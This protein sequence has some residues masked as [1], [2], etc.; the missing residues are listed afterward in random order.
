MTKERPGKPGRIVSNRS[1]L[2][3]AILLAQ[4][5]LEVDF[6]FEE[7]FELEAVEEVVTVLVKGALRVLQHTDSHLLAQQHGLATVGTPMY[8]GNIATVGN[9]NTNLVQLAFYGERAASVGHQRP[10]RFRTCAEG[11]Y[12]QGS[13]D[14]TFGVVGTVKLS[15]I[16]SGFRP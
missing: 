10:D 12:S 6:I 14:S 9:V 2:L 5:F 4:A 1:F 15:Q 7:A 11:F 16:S 8:A 3:L 13:P